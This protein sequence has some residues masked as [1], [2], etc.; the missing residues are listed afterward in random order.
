MNTY[1]RGVCCAMHRDLKKLYTSFVHLNNNM[2][3]KIHCFSKVN[4]LKN[5]FH[6]S[7]MLLTDPYFSIHLS[8]TYT[9]KT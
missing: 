7:H 6:S 4:L 9:F 3:N 8:R 5:L 2:Y 1:S